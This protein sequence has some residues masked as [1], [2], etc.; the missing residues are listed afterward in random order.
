[1]ADTTVNGRLTGRNLDLK[2][3][4]R[5]EQADEKVPWHFKLLVGL[6]VVY[7]TWRFIQLFS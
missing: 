5:S 7:L 1:M 4:A 2:A 3:L 6:L